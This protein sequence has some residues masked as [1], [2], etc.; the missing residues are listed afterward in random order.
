MADTQAATLPGTPCEAEVETK[1]GGGRG[2]DAL[3]GGGG[4]P[5]CA[6]SYC[7]QH[8]RAQLPN[9]SLPRGCDAPPSC[10]RRL[11]SVSVYLKSLP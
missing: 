9:R 7:W 5:K 3:G 4:A 10:P 8:T 2:R 6:A 1:R 11:T